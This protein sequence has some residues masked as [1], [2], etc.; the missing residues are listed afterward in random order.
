M[1]RRIANAMAEV[2]TGRPPPLPIRPDPLFLFI[3]WGALT[4]VLGDLAGLHSV[5]LWSS[6]VK[7][8][9]SIFLA[10]RISGLAG[11]R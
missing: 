5:R 2:P 10:R 8:V 7:H 4:G 11:W 1:T 3:T 9:F 6:W